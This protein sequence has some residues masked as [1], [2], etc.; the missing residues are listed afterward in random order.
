MTASFFEQLAEA[1]TPAPVKRKMEW[2]EKRAA[3]AREAEKELKEQDTLSR[4]YRA[5]K[6]AKRDAL[7]SGPHGREV[8]GIV[9][10]LDS[11]TLSSAP[12]LIG[13]VER[14]RFVQLMTPAE[15]AD[16]LNIVN[17][18]IARCREKAGLP[19]FDDELPW[20]EPPKASAQLKVMLEVR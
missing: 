1:Q 6:Q 13:L 8:R 16:L 11:M 14:A 20:C 4:L 10:F 12:A 18:G 9:S 7:L 3:K 2:A 19:P 15:R 5:W 17:I